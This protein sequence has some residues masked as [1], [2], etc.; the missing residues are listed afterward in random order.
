MRVGVVGVRGVRSGVVGVGS[1]KWGGGCGERGVRGGVVGVVK[2]SEKWGG[3]CG[4]E[5]R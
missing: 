1:E 4:V 3:G 5:W 2:G